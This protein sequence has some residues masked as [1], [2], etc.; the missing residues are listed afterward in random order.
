MDRILSRRLARDKT[1][2]NEIT[3]VAKDYIKLGQDSLNYFIGDYDAA[4]DTL[5]CFAPLSRKDLENLEKGH[6]KRF[7]LPVAS[8]QIT[9]MTTYITQSLFGGTTPFKVE[10]RGGDDQNAAEFM[11]QLLRWNTDMLP[12]FTYGYLWVQDSLVFNRAI[13]LASWDDITRS[14]VS[15]EEVQDEESLDEMGQP[16]TYFRQI[17]VREKVGGYNRIDLISPYDWFCD[18]NL[19]LTRMQE[20]RFTGHRLRVAWGELEKRSKLPVDDPQYLLPDAVEKLKKSTRRPSVPD[21]GS[22]RTGSTG[23][24]MESRTAFERNLSSGAIGNDKANKKD[25][26]IVDLYEVWVK[27]SAKDLGFSDSEEIEIWQFVV[28]N[29][30]ELLSVN[31][32][33]YDHDSF[34]YAVAEARPSGTTQFSPSWMLM[35]RPLQLFIDYLKNRHQEAMSRTMGNIFVAHVNKVNLTDFM[36]PDKEGLIIP[37]L[38]EV[39]ASESL[40][41]IIKQIPIRDVTANFPEEMTQLINFSETVSAANSNMQGQ[42]SG[43]GTATE[44]VGTQQMSAGRMASIARLLS[45]SALVP[46]TKQ[47]VS[48]FQQFMEGSMQIRIAGDEVANSMLFQGAKSITVTRDDVQG[49]FDFIAADISLP[50][51]DGKKV[52]ALRQ[53]F[54]SAMAFPDMFAPKAGNFNPKQLLSELLRAAHVSPDNFKYRQGDPDV[55]AAEQAAQ[56][57]SQP[58][59]PALSEGDMA[60]GEGPPISDGQPPQGLPTQGGTS[61]PQLSMEGLD[62]TPSDGGTSLPEAK[63]PNLVP[64]FPR[65]ETM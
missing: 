58:P 9:T 25:G 28:G 49:D 12:M 57:A 39:P 52:A 60:P 26:G 42:V 31:P 44:F 17:R 65:P 54:E 43:D 23:G 59:P 41:N 30:E 13:L 61:L 45:Q 40:D 14:R 4:H 55:V 20:M 47:L 6:P 19:P 53:A 63:L 3:K 32:S 29:G 16:E 51:T 64:Q 56:A 15:M 21:G 5:M 10:G 62:Q 34:P 7:M 2:C 8:T 35:L 27:M 38:P 22:H 18:P 33:S 48:N 37:V 46:L 50:G 11:N 36:N 1:F 24:T